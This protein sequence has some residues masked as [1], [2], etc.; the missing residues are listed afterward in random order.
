MCGSQA[1]RGNLCPLWAKSSASLLIPVGVRVMLL[2][3]CG[4]ITPIPMRGQSPAFLICTSG[5]ASDVRIAGPGYFMMRDP[6]RGTVE[7]TR[8]GTFCCDTMGYLVT[9]MGLRVQGFSDAGLTQIGD[10]CIC[11]SSTPEWVAAF[12]IQ[13]DGTILVTLIDGSK[14]VAGQILLQNFLFP[15]NLERFLYG[16]AFI[17]AAAQPLPQPAPPGSQGLGMLVTGQL[18]SPTP[19]LSLSQIHPTSPNATQGILTST[20][21]PTDLAIFGPGF[22]VVRDTNSGVCYATRAGALYLDLNG[23]LINYAGMRVQGYND[24]SLTNVGDLA[25]NTNGL[26]FTDATGPVVGCSFDLYGN[27]SAYLPDGTEFSCGQ[28]LLVNCSQPC[29]LVST[30]FGLYAMTSAGGP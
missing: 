2:L 27:I 4:I 9:S 28:I 1:E 23:Y 30:N 8:S 19:L 20:G 26:E 22:F 21:I 5:I 16:T 13:G 17:T 3:L 12:A 6:S 18:E 15:E 24:S 29:P 14:L 7:V 11:S 25:I 10:V